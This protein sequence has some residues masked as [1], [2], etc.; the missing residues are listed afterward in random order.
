MIYGQCGFE[1]KTKVSVPS[2]LL[3]H[4]I[5]DLLRTRLAAD[6]SRL[7]KILKLICK[8]VTLQTCACSYAVD[9]SS[10]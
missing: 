1:K 8:K 3:Q 2:T 7:M 4:T 9:S 5:I 6:H 10:S